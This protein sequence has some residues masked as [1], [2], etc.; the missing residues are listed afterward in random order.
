MQTW[1]KLYKCLSRYPELFKPETIGFNKF[2]WVYILTMNRCF[3]S[4]WPC[5][6]QMVPFADQINHENVNVYYDCHDPVTGETCVSVE[7]RRAREAK[8]ASD[9]KEERAKYLETL[10]TD[11]AA[12]ADDLDAKEKKE[13]EDKDQ[14]DSSQKDP[15]RGTDSLQ[16]YK[17]LDEN[18]VWRIKTQGYLSKV[19]QDQI[20]ERCDDIKAILAER[21]KRLTRIQNA[22]DDL[23]SGLESDNDLDLLVE[24]E[25]IRA[26]K[27]RKQYK[28]ALRR[29]Q[30]EKAH[31]DKAETVQEKTGDEA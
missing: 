28:Q 26:I 5:V 27:L 10:S 2:K 20:D 22:E 15:S 1:N 12:I 30:L 31:Q 13:N 9:K 8:E 14:I 6:S 23:S 18:N 29:Q 7:E 16:I 25:V 19:Q 17:D 4:N 3:A 11:L 21:Q 24:Q